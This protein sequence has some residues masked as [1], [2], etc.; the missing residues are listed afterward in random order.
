MWNSSVLSSIM[1]RHGEGVPLLVVLM[2]A[3]PE[4]LLLGETLRLLK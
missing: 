4:S 1:A 2:K 3:V